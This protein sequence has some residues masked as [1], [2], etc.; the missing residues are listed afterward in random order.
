VLE[1]DPPQLKDALRCIL[2][3]ILFHRSLGASVAPKELESESFD[4]VLYVA[5]DD[6]ATQRSI[7]SFI[8][9][10][11]QK[12]VKTAEFK[13]TVGLQFYLTRSKPSW[14]S[15]TVEEKFVWERWNL[16]VVV[17]KS[18]SRTMAEQ[19]QKMAAR[20]QTLKNRLTAVVELVVAKKDHIPSINKQQACFPF[21]FTLDADEK[22]S[23]WNL[24]SITSMLKQGPPLLLRES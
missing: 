9:K 7:E 3:T 6:S 24:S 10:L 1:L 15:S 11:Y 18:K 21:E 17:S 12:A 4:G 19:E 5:V 16:P 13:T 22:S 8:D 2:N 14:F 23:S 20:G